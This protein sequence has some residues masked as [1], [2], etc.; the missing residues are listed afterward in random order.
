MLAVSYTHTLTKEQI[1]NQEQHKFV[2][3]VLSFY[4]KDG[5]YG[6]EY[7]WTEEQI[8]QAC[9]ERSYHPSWGDGDSV[10]REAV[11]DTL[12]ETI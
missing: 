1:M 2:K 3:Y 5:L 10:D 9:I 11:R 8:T 4:G 7:N 6:S 12:L